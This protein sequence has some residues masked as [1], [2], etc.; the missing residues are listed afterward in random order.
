MLI[1]LQLK[2]K[3]E[4]YNMTNQ[5]LFQVCNDGSTSENPLMRTITSTSERKTI[6]K[7]C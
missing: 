7:Y 6:I 4:L 2:K 5:D 1:I 3:K